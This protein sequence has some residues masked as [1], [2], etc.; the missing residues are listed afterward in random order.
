MMSVQGVRFQARWDHTNSH[1]KSPVLTTVQEV[2]RI[3]WNIFSFLIPIIGL[4]RLM[5]Y[6]VGCLANR[7]ILVRVNSY[8][9][10]AERIAKEKEFTDFWKG[11]LTPKNREVRQW[12]N[13]EEHIIA[14][15]DCA[16]LSVRLVQHQNAVESSPTI[17]RFPG[18]AEIGVQEGNHWMFYES[19]R[20]GPCNFVFFD[21]RGRR[22]DL[23]GT[24]AAT[25]DLTV[26]GSS[27]VQWVR[28]CLKTPAHQIRF[29]GSSLGGAVA[30]ETQG[31]DPKQL[32]GA[33]LNESSFASVDKMVKAIFGAGCLGRLIAWTVA[34]QGYS[35]EA[36]TAFE[37]LKGPKLVVYHPQDKVIPNSASLQKEVQHKQAI[38][39][40]AKDATLKYRPTLK[41]PLGEETSCATGSDE[42]GNH[43][44]PLNWYE[45]AYEKVSEFLFG[46]P[47]P[48]S[49]GR[50]LV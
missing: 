4:V 10:S 33:H 34:N 19:I 39:L 18:N 50:A 30:V 9:R 41:Y 27:V 37:K 15:P 24:F 2:K 8:L 45:G 7:L 28:K 16:A 43:C 3:A 21:Y 17:I 14:T 42:W 48:Q 32:T 46:A 36:A 6:G 20:R 29:Y 38:C 31:L 26:D 5:G 35:M 13:L 25:K 23:P 12:F 49:R 44:A 1:L 11:G 22:E 40:T 47:V